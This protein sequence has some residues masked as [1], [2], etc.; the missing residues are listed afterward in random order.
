MIRDE[1]FH[2]L[3]SLHFDDIR[4]FKR[5]IKNHRRFTIATKNQIHQSF[6]E[7]DLA[8][9]DINNSTISKLWSIKPLYGVSYLR[10]YL[11][12]SPGRQLSDKKSIDTLRSLPASEVSIHILEGME[13]GIERVSPR[14]PVLMDPI[15]VG[16]A[17]KLMREVKERTSRGYAYGYPHENCVVNA[18]SRALEQLKQAD[19]AIHNTKPRR[20]ATRR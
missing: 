10:I 15:L 11:L 8:F 18:T 13:T 1:L 19:D 4:V 12:Q 17:D 3:L 9:C 16:A 7:I 6:R 14:S 5:F 20:K 2:T